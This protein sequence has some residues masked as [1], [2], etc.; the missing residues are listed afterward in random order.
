MKTKFNFLIVML[1]SSLCITFTSCSDDDDDDKK[2]D[3]AKEITGEYKGD[4]Y[5]AEGNDTPI[6]TDAAIKVTR[7]ADNKVKLEMNQQILVM[8]IDI[9]YESDVVYTN[10][11]YSIK[12]GKTKVT[13]PVEGVG[14]MDIDVELDGSFDKEGNST[15]NIAVDIPNSPIKVIYKGKRQ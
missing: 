5:L 7:I 13:I 6:A 12:K 11:K 15:I 2:T 4:I 9:A 8:K 14:D 10:D 3:Y 1:L